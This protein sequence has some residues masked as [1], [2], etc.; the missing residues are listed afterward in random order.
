MSMNSRRKNVSVSL[1]IT[2]AGIVILIAAVAILLSIPDAQRAVTEN[3][4]SAVPLNAHIPAPEI[5]LID[6][7]GNRVSL[8]D[9][10]GNVVLVNNWATW[11][12]PC[13]AEMPALESY[14]RAHA[15]EGFM[16]IA[17]E[18]GAS[19]PE[20]IDFVEQYQLTFQVWLDP[21]G[22]ALAAFQ[23]WN[24]PSSYVIDRNGIIRMAWTG[25]VSET[26]LEEYLTPLLEE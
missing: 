14:Y 4:N 11:C 22:K 7:E 9:Y 21:D 20:V 15:K 13:K 5:T 2:I 8:S 25:A 23:N 17:I 10:R 12:P 16:V 26:V 19:A 3:I 24:L 1:W 18:S 6:L